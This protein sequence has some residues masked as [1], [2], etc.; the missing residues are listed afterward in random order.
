MF[1]TF[2]WG[3]FGRRSRRLVPCAGFMSNCRCGQHGSAPPT[4]GGAVAVEAA[5]AASGWGGPLRPSN[6]LV[7]SYRPLHRGGGTVRVRPCVGGLGEGQ[8]REP[9]ATPAASTGA[10]V[11]VQST[12]Q[13][14]G[15]QPTCFSACTDAASHAWQRAIPRLSPRCSSEATGSPTPRHAAGRHVRLSKAVCRVHRSETARAH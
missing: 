5:L 14:Q 8:P 12:R 7:P 2:V 9:G 4:S 11:G 1:A 13:E 3:S 10:G 6:V 15:K